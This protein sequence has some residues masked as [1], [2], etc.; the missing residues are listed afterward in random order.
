MLIDLIVYAPSA[1]TGTVT[2]QVAP[3]GSPSAGEWVN[4]EIGGVV[5]TLTAGQ[6]TTVPVGAAKALRVVSDDA[7]ASNRDFILVGQYEV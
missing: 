1:L 2:L 6:G 4:H 7:E 3:V 5:T